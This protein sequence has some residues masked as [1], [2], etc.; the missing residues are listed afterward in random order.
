MDCQKVCVGDTEHKSSAISL[1]RL[2]KIFQKPPASKEPAI[3]KMTGTEFTAQNNTGRRKITL[4]SHCESTFHLAKIS[5]E[6]RWQSYSTFLPPMH[7]TLM[8]QRPRLAA[9]KS[10]WKE[11][12]NPWLFQFPIE[13]QEMEHTQPIA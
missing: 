4:T 2:P 10:I 1:A 13:L 7:C 8:G 3:S 12:F 6:K 9:P 11:I 5:T